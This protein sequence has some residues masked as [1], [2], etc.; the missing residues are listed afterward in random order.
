MESRFAYANMML[1]TPWSVNSS[2]RRTH[3]SLNAARNSSPGRYRNDDMAHRRLLNVAP[4][5]A[6]RTSSSPS[7]PRRMAPVQMSSRRS[8]VRRGGRYSICAR[9][10]RMLAIVCR[11]MSSSGMSARRRETDSSVW[12]PGCSFKM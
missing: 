6:M 4:P 9:V 2:H 10:Y 8:I 3:C 11:C 7:A 12:S 1:D 5:C